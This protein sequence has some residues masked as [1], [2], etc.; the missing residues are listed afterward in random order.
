MIVMLKARELKAEHSNEFLKELLQIQQNHSM[1][2]INDELKDFT[3]SL[4]SKAFLNIKL[5]GSN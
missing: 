4:L 1:K 3:E 5:L 2:L